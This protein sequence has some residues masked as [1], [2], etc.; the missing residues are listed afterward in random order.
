MKSVFRPEFQNL[1]CCVFI[2]RECNCKPILHVY[3]YEIMRS[4]FW[5]RSF[6]ISHSLVFRGHSRFCTDG[7]I[8]IM[9]SKIACNFS[10]GSYGVR[11]QVKQPVLKFSY[12]FAL[13]NYMYI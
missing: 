1:L 7:C 6:L 3:C 2:S 4:S 12:L 11:V 8:T 10:A 9:C 13:I 5:L